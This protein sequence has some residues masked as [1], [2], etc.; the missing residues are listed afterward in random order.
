MDVGNQTAVGNVDT[1]GMTPSTITIRD[2]EFHVFTEENRTLLIWQE[3]SAYFVFDAW[4][5]TESEA[6]LAALSVRPMEDPGTEPAD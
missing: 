4:G 1:E 6:L 3:D 2:T 5:M